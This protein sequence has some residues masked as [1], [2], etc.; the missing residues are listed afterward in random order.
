M[1]T[2]QQSDE[3]IAGTGGMSLAMRYL[4]R[5]SMANMVGAQ[6]HEGHR[7]M[8]YTVDSLDAR[9]KKAMRHPATVRGLQN[10]PRLTENASAIRRKKIDMSAS[11]RSRERSEK[12]VDRR[13]PEG[14]SADQA[15]AAMAI[16]QWALCKAF[17]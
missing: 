6:R 7:G 2:I 13:S 17:S 1:T 12:A 8:T 4:R 14:R 16:T 15:T 11:Q 5:F 9:A 10:S 3:V